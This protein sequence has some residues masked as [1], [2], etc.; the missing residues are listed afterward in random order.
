MSFLLAGSLNVVLEFSSVE[1]PTLATAFSPAGGNSET[2]SGIPDVWPSAVLR[3][4]RVFLK[5][6]HETTNYISSVCIV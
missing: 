1:V 4:L 5:H 2:V 6:L 3:S